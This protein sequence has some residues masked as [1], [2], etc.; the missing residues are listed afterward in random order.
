[1]AKKLRQM[2]DKSVG[3]PAMYD[4][5]KLLNGS[6]WE[7][8]RGVDFDGEPDSFRGTVYSAAARAGLAVTVVVT[9]DT[10]TIQARGKA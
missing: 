8:S 4:W 2:P 7:L 6:V 5:L 9:G 10:V 3:R 1:M